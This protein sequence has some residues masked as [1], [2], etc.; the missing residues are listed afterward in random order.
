ME[1]CQVFGQVV[2]FMGRQPGRAGRTGTA[3]MRPLMGEIVP[4][5]DREQIREPLLLGVRVG[6]GCRV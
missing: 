3:A 5:D 6:L 2:D 4:M 1:T